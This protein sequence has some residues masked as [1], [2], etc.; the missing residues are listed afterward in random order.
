MSNT[1]LEDDLRGTFER[2]A[3]SVPEAD[4]LSERAVK[5]RELAMPDALHRITG[6]CL[7]LAGVAT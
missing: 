5:A 6:A 3:A 1:D 7:D 2:A 4:G